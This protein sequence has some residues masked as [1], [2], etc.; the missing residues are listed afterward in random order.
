MPVEIRALLNESTPIIV[1]NSDD[2]KKVEPATSTHILTCQCARAERLDVF[3]ELV[4]DI[5]FYFEGGLV[6][7]GLGWIVSAR[8]EGCL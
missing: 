5:L 2:P 1:T 7:K 8:E 6:W 3:T 4:D